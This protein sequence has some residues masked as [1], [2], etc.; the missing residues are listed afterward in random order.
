M[1]EFE[2]FGL[3]PPSVWNALFAVF[4]V[5]L[6]VFVLNELNSFKHELQDELQ[7]ELQAV[8]LRCSTLEETIKDSPCNYD[9]DFADIVDAIATQ[10]EAIEGVN[11]CLSRIS[12]DPRTLTSS[13]PM[14][15]AS[16]HE[17]QVWRREW[18]ERQE[19]RRQ[20]ELKMKLF[21]GWTTGNAAAVAE[22]AT[23]STT[24][25]TAAAA[26]TGAT[27]TPTAAPATPP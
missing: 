8:S 2:Q 20:I 13:L 9:K 1:E 15:K 6:A 21:K 7:A 14:K 26:A 24:P 16:K 3:A 18:E 10:N 11:A 5:F 27:S 19:W 12:N 17:Q 22:A 4:G 23:D 25:A